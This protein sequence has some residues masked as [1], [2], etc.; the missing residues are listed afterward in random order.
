MSEPAPPTE[1]CSN[2]G[3]PVLESDVRCP[4]CGKPRHFA[5]LGS[6]DRWSRIV[7][8]VFIGAAVTAL[9][10]IGTC[11]IAVGITAND[12]ES[13]FYGWLFGLPF[14]GMFLLALWAWIAS[15]RK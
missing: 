15:R 13:R 5:G 9:A 2:C 8:V 14:L 1:K 7:F 12:R 3:M 6:F 4:F 11:S 10:V